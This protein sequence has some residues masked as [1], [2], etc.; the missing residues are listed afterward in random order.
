MALKQVSWTQWSSPSA[1]RCQQN[2]KRWDASFRGLLSKTFSGLLCRQSRIITVCL[3][4]VPAKFA[5]SINNNKRKI[6]H[7]IKQTLFLPFWGGCLVSVTFLSAVTTASPG[8]LGLSTYFGFLIGPAVRKNSF[9]IKFFQMGF[10]IRNLNLLVETALVQKHET[11]FPSWELLF[12]Q[13]C[14]A[15]RGTL[16]ECKLWQETRVIH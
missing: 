8:T 7:K 16:L 11:Q 14:I 1:H 2:S 12:Q 10:K 13:V 6:I 9:W 5:A 15:H 4:T 3:S